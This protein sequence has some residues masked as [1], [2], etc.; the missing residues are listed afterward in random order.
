MKIKALFT[1]SFLGLFVTIS[2]SAQLEARFGQIP[3]EAL[4]MKA[5]S[6]KL[7]AQVVLRKP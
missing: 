5:F 1:F 6:E 4:G 3:P 7:T 2:I